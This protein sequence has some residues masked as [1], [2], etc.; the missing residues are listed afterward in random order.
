[1]TFDANSRTKP[2]WV[3]CKL[4]PA[5]WYYNYDYDEYM[6]DD[7]DD[8]EDDDDNECNI[9]LRT[10][11]APCNERLLSEFARLAKCLPIILWA[12]AVAVHIDVVRLEAEWAALQHVSGLAVPA[13]ALLFTRKQ[14]GN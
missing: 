1:M 5:S 6:Y 13:Y 12:P 14:S 11:S 9:T 4:S 7:N 8:D 3:T 10:L 2:A